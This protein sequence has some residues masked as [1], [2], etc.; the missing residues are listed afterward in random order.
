MSADT[1]VLPAPEPP[2]AGPKPPPAPG[3]PRLWLLVVVLL[4]VAAGGWGFAWW[5]VVEKDRAER[6]A[7][8]LEETAQA[9]EKEAAARREASEREAAQTEQAL[10]AAQLRQALDAWERHDVVGAE[11]ILDEVREPF[12]QSWETRFV[13]SLCRRKA[14]PLLGHSSAVTCMA[15]SPDGERIATG[16]SD[17]TVR[18]WDS[19]TGQEQLRL[20]AEGLVMCLAFSPDG[21]LLVTGASD[22]GKG[23]V[24]DSRTGKEKLYFGE[25]IS[26]A[27]FSPDGTRLA[28]GA[29]KGGVKIRD[30]RTGKVTRELPGYKGKLREICFSLDGKCLHTVDSDG[31]QVWDLATGKEDPEARARLAMAKRRGVWVSPDWQMAISSPDSRRAGGIFESPIGKSQIRDA[32]TGRLKLE[33]MGNVADCSPDGTQV[34]VRN[35]NLLQLWDVRTGQ[36]QVDLLGHTGP[37]HCLAFSPDG[38]RIASGCTHGTVRIWSPGAPQASFVLE[39][40]TEYILCMALSG[41]GMRIVTGGKGGTLKLWDARTGQPVRQWRGHA[42]EVRSVAFSPDGQRIASGGKDKTAR[43]WDV[44][45]GRELLALREFKKSVVCVGF[46]PDGE[47]LFAGEFDNT[48]S[49]WDSRTGKKVAG[50]LQEIRGATNAVWSRDG[51]QLAATF[52]GWS[53]QLHDAKTGQKTVRL[54]GH[55][56]PVNSVAFS[57]DGRLLATAGSDGAACVWDA[58]T[59]HEA[60][61]LPVH[62]SSVGDLSFSPD[63]RLLVSCGGVDFLTHDEDG[64]VC[65]WDTRTGQPKL[66]LRLPGLEVQWRAKQLPVR[67]EELPPK[68]DANPAPEHPG[69]TWPAKP[70]HIAFSSDGRLFA[71]GWNG[72]VAVYDCKYAREERHLLQHR[73]SIDAIKFSPDGRLI[74]THTPVLW[75]LGWK[76][77]DAKTGKQARQFWP[78]QGLA[79][80]LAFSPDSAL[81]VTP[82]IGEKGGLQIWD[83]HSGEKKQLLEGGVG[84]FLAFSPDGRN[85]ASEDKDGK[86]IVWDVETGRQRHVLQRP[87]I[88]GGWGGV[89]GETQGVAFSSDGKRVRTWV[90]GNGKHRF[91]FDAATGEPLPPDKEPLPAPPGPSARQPGTGLTAVASG[92]SV[93][94]FGPAPG[95]DEAGRFLI[96]QEEANW[97]REQAAAF[98]K[99]KNWFPAAFHLER[100]RRFHPR[101]EAIRQR[102]LEALRQAPAHPGTEAVRQ[103]AAE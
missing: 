59:G 51:K 43:V 44:Q 42:G 45:G 36:K 71:R 84:K 13:R 5:A 47:Q 73:Y 29:S 83:S 46:S 78:G 41:D 22:G 54:E 92:N 67:K 48:P 11:A 94:L 3:S 4:V 103:R 17:C 52:G 81:V 53:A 28:V 60:L 27:A 25:Y 18:L 64:T 2:P 58:E 86:V 33:V 6:H 72:K 69:A 98:E 76:V 49:I 32:G 97:H 23:R 85:L 10:H 101:D 39:D 61:H 91:D 88:D 100:L 12:R 55:R 66:R 95:I 65:L 99:A 30:V 24:W 80:S 68:G 70:T 34:A 63:S 14:L 35:G 37:I 87:K 20:A 82:A 57:P 74:A 56:G 15:F 90:V 9:A 93:L 77:W 31:P 7:G 1:P 96:R 79:S 89:W 75:A 21:T 38:R 40:R 26:C 50:G 102:L 19:R 62:R 8:S 16:S